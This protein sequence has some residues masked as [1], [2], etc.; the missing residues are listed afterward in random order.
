MLKIN[1]IYYI[2]KGSSYKAIQDVAIHI[3]LRYKLLTSEK[4]KVT[5]NKYHL[6]VS[7]ADSIVSIHIDNIGI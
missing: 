6:F 7:F 5:M 1:K 2:E 4:P 3:H